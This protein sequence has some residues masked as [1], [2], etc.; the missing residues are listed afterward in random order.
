MPVFEAGV[1]VFADPIQFQELSD[2][3]NMGNDEWN[4]VTNPLYSPTRPVF[5]GL[6]AQDFPGFVPDVAQPLSQTLA[7]GGTNEATQSGSLYGPREYVGI[8]KPDWRFRHGGVFYRVVGDPNFDI[9]H[10][11]TGEDFGYVQWTIRK[12]G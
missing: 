8:V 4:N 10:P 5:K 12:G 3:E 6:T 11:L 9:D 1:T 7:R 2:P